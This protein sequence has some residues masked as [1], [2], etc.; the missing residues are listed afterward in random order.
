[1]PPC[2]MAMEFMP[3]TTFSPSS[4]WPAAALVHMAIATSLATIN[5]FQIALARTRGALKVSIGHADNT[6]LHE[7]V[8]CHGNFV[9]WVPMVLILM[10]IAE[11][12]GAD[13]IYVHI[14]G[15]LLVLGRLAH[16]FGLKA[17]KATHVLR[18]VGNS[19]N[20]LATLNV[21]I[22]LAVRSL[23]Y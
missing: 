17:E 6:Q 16:P 22:C 12:L 23:G 5:W 19:A 21:M 15:A 14:T 18:I 9:E 4:S 11:S 7:R 3:P 2:C 20:I 8:R 13:A 10:I 1:M